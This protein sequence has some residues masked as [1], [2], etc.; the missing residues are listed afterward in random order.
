MDDDSQIIDNNRHDD[1][2]ASTS[3]S[4]TPLGWKFERLTTLPTATMLIVVNLIMIG[5]VFLIPGKLTFNNVDV[6]MNFS[7]VSSPNFVESGFDSR[8][9]FKVNTKALKRKPSQS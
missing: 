9:V 4:V 5:L 1:V 8:F 3:A 7:S 6:K 2:T